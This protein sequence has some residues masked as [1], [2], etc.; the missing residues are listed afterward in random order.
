MDTPTDSASR[1][2]RAPDDAADLFLR[3]VASGDSQA[4]AAVFDDTAP[5]LL[6]IALRLAGNLPDAEDLVQ[7]TFVAALESNS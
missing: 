6:R 3:F 1:P 7:E 4:L 5:V 2:A